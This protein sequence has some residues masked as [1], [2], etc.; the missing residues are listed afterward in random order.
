MKP[1][2][3]LLDK[4]GV[5][6]KDGSVVMHNTNVFV[7]KWSENLNEWILRVKDDT[8]MNWRNLDWFKKVGK[9]CEIM[10]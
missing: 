9:Y 4:N 3:V 10:K 2:P 5:Q 8:G 1:I 6:L 7:V